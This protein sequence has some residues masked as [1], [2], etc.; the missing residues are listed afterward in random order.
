MTMS[1]EPVKELTYEEKIAKLD[2]IL[3]RLDDSET[4]IDKLADAGFLG[5]DRSRSRPI[6]WL[7]CFQH[8]HGAYHERHGCETKNSHD[9]ATHADTSTRTMNL[10]YSFRVERETMTQ[11]S[12]FQGLHGQACA[13]V[14][15]ESDRSK[16]DSRFDTGQ[17]LAGRH[18]PE[19]NDG[20]LRIEPFA[21]REAPP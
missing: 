21:I 9:P 7:I 4:P 11:P 12:V 20:M 16:G 2:E 15:R 14:G 17:F 1:E 3:T 5:P 18:V 19:N 8:Q 10:L 6:G 13:A